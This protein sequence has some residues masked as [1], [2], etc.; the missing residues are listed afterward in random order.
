MSDSFTVHTSKAASFH[1]RSSRQCASARVIA[2][3]RANGAP[4]SLS[5]AASSRALRAAGLDGLRLLRGAANLDAVRL[6]LRLLVDAARQTQRRPCWQQPKHAT[7]RTQRLPLLNLASTLLMSQLSG[8]RSERVCTLAGRVSDKR[9]C[10]SKQHA[11]ERAAGAVPLDVIAR[12]LIRHLVVGAAENGCLSQML[13]PTMPLA[14]N[15]TGADAPDAHDRAVDLQVDVLLLHAGDVPAQAASAA[16][17]SVRRPTSHT[18]AARTRSARASATA[19]ARAREKARRARQHQKFSAGVCP[20]AGPL[21]RCSAEATRLRLEDV[22]RHGGAAAR[23]GGAQ[24]G[25]DAAA[26]ARD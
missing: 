3:K 25:I 7:H 16:A 21:E 14:Q 5:A 2:S 20:R 10:A 15:K 23:A 24:A 8:K 11:P 9:R 4:H 12:V 17:A 13:T 1:S 18:S 6:G 22:R 26:H 19:Q